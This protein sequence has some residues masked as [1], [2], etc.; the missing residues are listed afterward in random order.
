MGKAKTRSPRPPRP[1]GYERMMMLSVGEVV[2][3]LGVEHRSRAAYWRLVEIGAPAIPAVRVGLRSENPAVRRGCCEFLDLYWDEDA[4]P[5]VQALLADP[6]PEVRWMAA[7][8]LI[9]ERCKNDTWEKR[10][11]VEQSVTH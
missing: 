8:A 10:A 6:E 11:P 2:E 9:C 5:E 4:V 1:F 7:H 3:A